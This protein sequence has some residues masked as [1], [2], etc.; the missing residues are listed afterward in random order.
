VTRD[1]TLT[2]S[3]DCIIGVAA[4]KVPPTSIPT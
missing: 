1:E 2:V 3:G 4:D